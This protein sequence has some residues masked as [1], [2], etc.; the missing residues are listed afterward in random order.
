MKRNFNLY[1]IIALVVLSAVFL[2]S[3]K[4][5]TPAS[6]IGFTVFTFI[7]TAAAVFFSFRFRKAA[8]YP[9]FVCAALMPYFTIFFVIC[10]VNFFV[11]ADNIC[12][13]LTVAI[14]IGGSAAI[15]F[16]YSKN[17]VAK[18]VAAIAFTLIFLVILFFII[19]NILIP[20]FNSYTVAEEA[21]S[22][23]GRHYA[24][25][26]EIDSGALGGNTIVY[27][28]RCNIV[29]PFGTI[30]SRDIKITQGG[31]S[32][33]YALEWKDDDTLIVAGKEYTI[34]K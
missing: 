20:S 4:C 11:I 24:Y 19:C 26:L 7:L 2:V 28:R 27:M 12:S 33:R 23:N 25:T 21:Y 29:L 5:F 17:A 1:L 6:D 31:W 10:S 16:I 3:G 34:K 9:S 15:F 30:S 18:A 14:C 13:W 8:A 22:P 32:N